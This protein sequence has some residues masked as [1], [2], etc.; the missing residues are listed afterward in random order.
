MAITSGETRW[1]IYVN[2]RN[3]VNLRR[4]NGYNPYY[5]VT[6]GNLHEKNS[7]GNH[8]SRNGKS[9]WWSE[10]DRPG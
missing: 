4:K 8:G 6:G 10:A 5:Y 7:I 1:K 9:I 3:I 2:K